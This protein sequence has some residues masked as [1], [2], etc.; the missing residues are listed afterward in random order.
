MKSDRPRA[1]LL[2]SGS[3]RASNAI[4]LA[5]PANVHHALAP[6]MRYPL[7]PSSSAGSARHLTDATSEPVSGSVTE[8]ATISSPEA[9]RGSHAFFCAGEPAPIHGALGDDRAS[10]RPHAFF[11]GAVADQAADLG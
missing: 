2:M 9:M 4:T 11:G 7:R 10:E 3:V 6:S 1:P 5:R 8:M